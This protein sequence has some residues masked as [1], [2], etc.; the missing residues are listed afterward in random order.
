[1]TPQQKYDQSEK[2]KAKRAEYQ[3]SGKSR[4]AQ[5]KY[6]QSA[7][8]KASRHCAQMKA[9]HYQKYWIRRKYGLSEEAYEAMFREQNGRCAICDSVNLNGR[10][11]SVDHNHRTRKVRALLC[12]ACNVLIA[13]AKE[14]ILILYKAADY[15]EKHNGPAFA[16]PSVKE[17]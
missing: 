14:S 1:M 6:R 10:R 2:G 7:K 5:R 16:C 3:K 15:L 17:T 12:D 4:E 8:Y 11:L 9:N 13:R